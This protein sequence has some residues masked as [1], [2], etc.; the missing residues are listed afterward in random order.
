MAKVNESERKAEVLLAKIAMELKLKKS[1][2]AMNE[3]LLTQLMA[4]GPNA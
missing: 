3:S 4:S 1:R 2:E